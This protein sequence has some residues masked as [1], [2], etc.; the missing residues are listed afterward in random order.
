M[1]WS[2]PKIISL[3]LSETMDYVNDVEDPDG[4]YGDIFPLGYGREQGK[5]GT[6]LSGTDS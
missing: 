5:C 6:E 1:K 3:E 4:K 2:E